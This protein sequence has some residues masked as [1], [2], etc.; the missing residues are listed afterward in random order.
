MVK[1]S[2]QSW[3]PHPY[4][5]KTNNNQYKTPQTYKISIKSVEQY[6]IVYERTQ[7]H[8]PDKFLTQPQSQKPLDNLPECHIA[9]KT[10]S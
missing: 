1:T 10:E 6:I 4:Q 2:A 9:Y 8:D 3:T 7:H 5:Q